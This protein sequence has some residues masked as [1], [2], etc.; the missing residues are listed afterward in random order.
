M[1]G[2]HNKV[3]LRHV[4]NSMDVFFCVIYRWCKVTKI[5]LIYEVFLF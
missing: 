2:F 5:W 4:E 3:A 1:A